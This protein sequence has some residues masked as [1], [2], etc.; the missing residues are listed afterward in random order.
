MLSAFNTCYFGGLGIPL[1][2]EEIIGINNYRRY[3]RNSPPISSSPF[4]EFLQ[5]GKNA[6]GYFEIYII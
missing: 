3:E 4:L 6:E 5:Y 1:S 2:D